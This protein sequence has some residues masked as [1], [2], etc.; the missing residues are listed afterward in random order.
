MTTAVY[1]DSSAIVRLAVREVE[2]DALRR[3]LGRRRTLASSGLARAEVLR[4]ALRSGD[5]ALAAARRVLAVISLVRVNDRFLNA[6]G[7]LLPA[8]VG[9]LDAIH[10]ATAQLLGSD[11]HHLVTYDGRMADTAH[12]LGIKTAAPN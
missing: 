2:S 1:L 3:H 12:R 7:A 6:A 5:A 9:S 4:S 10:L 11:L 8:E